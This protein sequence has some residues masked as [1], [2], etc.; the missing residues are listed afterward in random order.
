M[1]DNKKRIDQLKLEAQV[2]VDEFKKIQEKIKELVVARDALKM[3]AF[4]CSERI[5]ELEGVQQ[6]PANTEVIN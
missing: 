6:I 2:A 3:K 1:S 4:S 5:N